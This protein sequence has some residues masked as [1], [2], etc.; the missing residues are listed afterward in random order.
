MS[1]GASDFIRRQ[2][3]T[4]EIDSFVDLIKKTHD[5]D[6][7]KK[8]DIESY[9]INGG[10]NVRKNGREV[11]NNAFRCIEKI[12]DSNLTIEVISPT[13]DWTEWMKTIGDV[14]GSN[15]KYAVRFCGELLSF[16]VKKTKKGYMVA[17]PEEVIKY[18][19]TF[20]K[21]FRQVFRKAAYC[22]ACRVCETN[23]KNGCIGFTDGKVQINNCS[24]C[25]ECHKID[26]GCLLF[27]SLRHP[28]GVQLRNVNS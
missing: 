18:K 9:I 6:K 19:P 1:G 21:M 15:G 8:K 27:H 20:S 26:S 11:A 14:H 2:S 23:C 5:G 24:R 3:Y 13:S 7:R 25:H 4:A 28:Q 16:T 12:S 17:I 10:W 22:K